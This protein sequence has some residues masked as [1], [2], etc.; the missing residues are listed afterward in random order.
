MLKRINA[1]NRMPKRQ[2]REG[3]HRF[4]KNKEFGYEG[5][6]PGGKRIRFRA[7]LQNISIRRR[8]NG[9]PKR[10]RRRRVGTASKRA[11]EFGYGGFGREGNR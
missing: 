1:L 2:T 9:T 6:R 4:Q 5:F 11:Q 7:T 3:G 10:Q 8:I